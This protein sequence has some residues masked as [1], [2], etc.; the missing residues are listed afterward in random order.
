MFFN[1]RISKT[2]N[3]FYDNQEVSSLMIFAS[4]YHIQQHTKVEIILQVYVLVISCRILNMR[5]MVLNFYLCMLLLFHLRILYAKEVVFLLVVEGNG[6]FPLV[7][8]VSLF[9]VD[10]RRERDALVRVPCA[11]S[12]NV[13]CTCR[14]GISLLGEIADMNYMNSHM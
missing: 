7:L 2:L 14:E 1:R 4:F 13:V 8:E 11:S 3:R 10:L 9:L 5:K 12:S 6:G